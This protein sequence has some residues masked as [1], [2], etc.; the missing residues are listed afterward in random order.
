MNREDRSVKR[1]TVKR[2]ERDR[3]VMER[4]TVNRADRADRDRKIYG[5]TNGEWH[6]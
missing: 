1:L 3:Q 5:K 4:L 6:R 2:T